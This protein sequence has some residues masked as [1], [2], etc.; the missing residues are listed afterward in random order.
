[1]EKLLAYCSEC[2]S[3]QGIFDDEAELRLKIAKPKSCADCGV[4]FGFLSDGRIWNLRWDKIPYDKAVEN[5]WSMIHEKIIKVAIKK[6]EDGHYADAVESSFKEINTHIKGIVRDK[7][8]EELDG[9]KLMFKA[10][11][12]KTPIILLADLST[13]TGKDIQEGYMQ[14]FAGA[15]KGIRNPKAHENITISRERAT[16]FL[17]LASLLM[18]KLDEVTH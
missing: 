9:A 1:M 14:I 3:A 17:F 6:F 13:Q 8:G 4:T 18:S 10:F 2:G 12:L 16:H 11:S 5:F 7:T 15:M